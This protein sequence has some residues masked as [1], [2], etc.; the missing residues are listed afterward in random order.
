MAGLVYTI[1]RQSVGGMGLSYS[2]SETN[3]QV[4]R[5]RNGVAKIP[6]ISDPLRH[7]DFVH[8]DAFD[9]LDLLDDHDTLTYCD[10]PYVHGNRTCTKLYGHEMVDWEHCRLL[11]LL[12]DL[13]GKVLV[14]GYDHPIY[15][16][17]LEGWDIDIKAVVLHAAGA[18]EV[19]TRTEYLWANYDFSPHSTGRV[20][21]PAA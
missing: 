15:Q 12:G 10:P 3:D 13:N 14:S 19:T 1:R 6:L 8:A 11:R 16:H 21:A 7:V 4:K 5:R 9:W 2:H 18:T 17:W 20:Y